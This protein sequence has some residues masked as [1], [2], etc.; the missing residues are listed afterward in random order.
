MSKVLGHY[1]NT[2]ENTKLT[3]LSFCSIEEYRQVTEAITML[4]C[5]S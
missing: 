5:G 3:P 4:R 1:S 2:Q